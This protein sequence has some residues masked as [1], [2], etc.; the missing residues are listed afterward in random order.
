MLLFI[1]V[2]LCSNRNAGM[3]LLS[4]GC[5]S[6]QCNQPNYIHYFQ[7][8]EH[9]F[10][11]IPPVSADNPLIRIAQDQIIQTFA[12]IVSNFTPAP[13][14][15]V[16]RYPGKCMSVW[17]L[18]DSGGVNNVV[19]ACE[20]YCGHND[21]HLVGS[22]LAAWS[23]KHSIPVQ[24]LMQV[25]FSHEPTTPNTVAVDGMLHSAIWYIVSRDPAF[26]KT[27]VTLNQIC[28]FLEAKAIVFYACLHGLG[29]GALRNAAVLLQ[30]SPVKSYSECSEIGIALL[31]RDQFVS[32][33]LESERVCN[34]LPRVEL[35][36][37][38]SGGVHHGLMGHFR[39]HA[40]LPR[41]AN[42]SEADWTFP[43]Q[44]SRFPSTCFRLLKVAASA[45]KEVPTSSNLAVCTEIRN[46]RMVRGCIYGMSP[47]LGESSSFDG[48][49]NVTYACSP[50]LAG[51]VTS[52]LQ[53][54]RIL[55]CILGISHRAARLVDSNATFQERI[56]SFCNKVSDVPQ[57][58]ASSQLDA[59]RICWTAANWR[60]KI[61][62]WKSVDMFMHGA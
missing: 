21:A 16:A 2:C 42:R 51:N 3:L 27:M 28:P 45:W 54:R 46:E 4:R 7:V 19:D 44:L 25:L 49:L 30:A 48:S 1:L 22:F 8:P 13:Q 6:F 35:G 14:V 41:L 12:R 56:L 47:W 29:H 33:M 43:C 62:S 34:T 5:S 32:T 20:M 61:A 40:D 58:N 24:F 39:F 23:L 60:S 36:T 50:L 57:L 55:S 9:F 59:A 17:R 37:G 10:Q 53:W 11:G 18:A 52:F 38:C 31:T 26:S 15:A